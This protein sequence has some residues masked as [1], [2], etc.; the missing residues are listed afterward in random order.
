MG[1]KFKDLVV[2]KEIKIDDL[3]G[4]K[5]VF[6][7]FNMLYQFLSNIRLRDGSL[8]M[9]T[10]GRITSHLIGILSRVTPLIE[11]GI[12]PAFVFDGKAPDLKK[13]ERERR[14]G[15]KIVAQKKFE[16]AERAGDVEEMKRY[17]SMTSFLTKPMIESA[18]ELLK[19]MGLPV[20]QAPSEGE[21]QMAY[22]IKKGD[23][24]AGVSQDYDS[25]MFGVPKLVRNLTIS[26][27]KKQ[28]GRLNYLRISPEIIDLNETLE[29]LKISREQLII[30]GI[31]SGTDYNRE[32]IMGIG[33]KKALKLVKKYK[34]TEEDFKKIFQEVKWDENSEVSWEKIYDTIYNMPT[35]DEYELKWETANMEK[36]KEF[37]IDRDFSEQRI[38]SAIEKLTK[39]NKSKQQKGLGDFF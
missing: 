17:A 32:G 24:Y 10:K 8:L 14:K 11:K 19:L 2:K 36:L 18:K 39:S 20:I 6:D 33:P 16:E 13:E 29:N 28:K 22:M 3:K 26:G 23:A 1:T 37:L 25:L 35:T 27:K 5:V 9:D 7:T 4:K 38:E 31:L 12:K 30:I 21:A 34:N 15:V